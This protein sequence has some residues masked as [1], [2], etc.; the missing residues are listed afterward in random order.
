[1]SGV[2]L[3][4]LVIALSASVHGDCTKKGTNIADI[5]FM[6]DVS[7]SV[8]EPNFKKEL[9]FI[10]AFV[11]SMDIGPQDVQIG[12][13]TYGAKPVT[14]VYLK[15]RKTEKDLLAMIPRIEYHA[16][17]STNTHLALAATT[18]LFTAANGARKGASQILVIITD[19]ASGNPGA[20]QAEAAKLKKAGITVV[21]I[22][23]GKANNKEIQ[24]MS[25]D[26]KLYTVANFA[27]LSKMAAEVM[28][29]ACEAP[30]PDCRNA[31]ADIN[32][33]LD[34]SGSISAPDFAKQLN[35]VKKVVDFYDIGPK[36]VQVGIATFSNAVNQKYTLK[37][38]PNKA[39]LMKTISGLKKTQGGT[40]TGLGLDYIL[41]SG[42]TKANGD[43]DDASDLLFV[44][45]DGASNNAAL[46]K[47]NAKKLHDAGVTVSAI[48]V[49][50]AVKTE[51]AAIAS[52][53][54]LVYHVDKFDGLL[55]KA[56]QIRKDAC[57]APAKKCMKA[58]MDIH[59]LL[60]VSGSIGSVDFS[61]ELGFVNKFVSTLDIG[62][63]SVQI[64]CTTYSSGVFHQFWLN[65]NKDKAH[66]LSAL[67]K[68]KKSG[69]T[70]QTHEGL[71]FV[72]KSAFTPAHGGRPNAADILVVLT[73]GSS[74]SKA[75][76]AAAA[77]K[78]HAAK[79]AVFA[80]GGGPHVDKA[81]LRSIASPT[82]G[83]FTVKNFDALN[84]IQNRLK[85]D[86]CAQ[87]NPAKKG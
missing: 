43:R 71:D 52:Q 58:T 41:K 30:A 21:A 15:Q 64:G 82:G 61:K 33:L 56:N 53:S 65:T 54:N 29:T 72:G 70:T 17:G 13:S 63:K 20:T 68:V 38:S 80:V 32:I 7:G 6:L 35:F 8:G 31:P 12:I 59:F 27:A 57:E 28:K 49:G 69:G 22:G 75:A 67:A 36:K 66:V 19:G 47:A 24:G 16:E 2:W 84:E 3:V 1:V 44:V 74:Q 81:E 40:A 76:T 55:Q 73:D 83:V 77:K 37:Q 10:S 39:A 42:F 5:N 14:K 51:L 4:A 79:V 25:T 48:G 9:D 45:T 11:K 78:L 86:A 62:P 23:V 46:T 50:A 34:V 26:G 85:K 18:N 87:T 60:D